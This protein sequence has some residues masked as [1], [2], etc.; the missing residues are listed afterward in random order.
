[1]LDSTGSIREPRES[2]LP[3]GLTPRGQPASEGD[4]SAARGTGLAVA[5]ASEREPTDL[6]S[7]W[8]QSRHPEG[9][10]RCHFFCKNPLAE[11]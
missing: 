3:V 10:Q 4:Y 11:I 7:V 8:A 9:L 5:F 6:D 2:P 1:M